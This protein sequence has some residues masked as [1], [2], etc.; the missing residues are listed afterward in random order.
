MHIFIYIYIYMYIYIY[1]YLNNKF[2]TNLKEK[3]KYNIITLR[4][5][6]PNRE[7]LPVH[8]FLYSVRILENMV[9][10]KSPPLDSF[11]TV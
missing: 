7:F 4:E 8:I 5:K 2:N 6:G 3:Q 9:Q 10:T 11:H 1:T